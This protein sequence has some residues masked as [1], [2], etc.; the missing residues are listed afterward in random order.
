MEIKGEV[1]SAKV[2]R[3]VDEGTGRDITIVDLRVKIPVSVKVPV[4]EI[5]ELAG[6]N[7]IVQIEKAQIALTD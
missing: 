7:A 4:K 2:S 5:I 3:K 1:R 6:L